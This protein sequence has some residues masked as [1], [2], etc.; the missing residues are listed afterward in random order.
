M[1]RTAELLGGTAG[2]KPQIVLRPHRIGDVGWVIE[3]QARLYAEEYGWNGEYEALVCEIGAAFIRNFQPG[4]EFCWIA[5]VGGERAGAVF[6]VR[7]SEE[8]GQLRLLHVERAARGL[9]VGIEAGRRNAS[10]RRGR[11]ATP[12]W[13][14]GPTTCWSTPGASTNAPASRSSPKSGTTASAR[15][16]SARIGSWCCEA[17]WRRVGVAVSPLSEG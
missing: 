14:C 4:K 3:R 2:E 12:S 17:G 6:L 5:E 9:G 16:W 8:E 11:S 13:C 10:R 7:K 15:I 1:Q